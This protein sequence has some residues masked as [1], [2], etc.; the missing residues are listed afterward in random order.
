MCCLFFQMATASNLVDYRICCELC[1]KDKMK[2]SERLFL[3]DS[4]MKRLTDLASERDFL[5]LPMTNN[6]LIPI[7]K[8]MPRP[9][10][11]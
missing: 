6:C 3:M 4:S 10:V 5:I 1:S 9:V 7:V 11:R 8:S 2:D